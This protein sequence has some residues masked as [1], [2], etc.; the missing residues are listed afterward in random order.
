MKENAKYKDDFKKVTSILNEF[1]LCGLIEGGAPSD[2]YDCLTNQILSS[3]Y[4]KNTRSQIKKQII[5]ELIYHFGTLNSNEPQ[6][7]YKT[8]L[9]LTLDKLL[10]RM[11]DAL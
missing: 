5:H 9:D 7:P 3:V 11:E 2:E 1:D 8:K 4:K 6:E 10:D